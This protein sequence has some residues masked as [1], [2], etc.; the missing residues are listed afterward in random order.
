VPNLRART[1]ARA[2]E[3]TGDPDALAEH[4]QITPALLRR[5]LSGESL[6]PEEA[7]LRASEIITAAGVKDAE[8]SS[9]PERTTP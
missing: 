2:A 5:Y 8:K 6:I 9:P 1:L 4:L 7:F 3:L